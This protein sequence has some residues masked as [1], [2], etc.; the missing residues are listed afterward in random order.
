MKCRTFSKRSCSV[1]CK[2]GRGGGRERGGSLTKGR[3]K[4]VT[5]SFQDSTI[6][7]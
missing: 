4:Y 6:V 5:T 3:L 1:Q 7:S 2:P